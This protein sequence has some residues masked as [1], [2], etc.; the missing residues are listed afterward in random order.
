VLWGDPS[1]L[2]PDPGRSIWNILF[3]NYVGYNHDYGSGGNDRPAATKEEI[4]AFREW[5]N[6]PFV[7]AYMSFEGSIDGRPSFGGGGGSGGG[8]S[9][10]NQ[11]GGVINIYRTWETDNST[12]STFNTGSGLKGYILERPGPA[13]TQSGLRLRIPAGTY[14]L[15]NA[16]G[17][18]KDIRLHAQ[19]E[20]YNNQV[21]GSRHILFHLGNYP[22]DTDGCLLIGTKRG[23]DFVG[24]DPTMGTTSKSVTDALNNYIN[25]FNGNVVVHIYDPT[26]P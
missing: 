14:N 18:A 10:A 24:G 11:A 6:T 4:D 16:P 22:D 7:P 26:K 15:T 3:G 21:P 5:G 2:W 17:T 1:G 25:S 12:I 13:T 19:W 9:S 20:L 8:G 23:V